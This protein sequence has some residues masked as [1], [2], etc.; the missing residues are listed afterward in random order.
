VRGGFAAIALTACTAA[1]AGTAAGAFAQAYSTETPQPR[2][3]SAATLRAAATASELHARFERGL[4]AEAAAAWPAAIAEF[5]RIIALDPGEPR[6]STARYDLAIALAH[7][8]AYE[9]AA[10]LLSDALARDPGFAAAAA[11]LVSVEVLAGN[12]PRARAAAERFVRIAPDA[13]RAHYARGLLALHDGDLSTARSDFGALIGNDP[14]YAI[15]HYDLALVE[16]RAER[17]DV[18]QAELQRAL[19]LA[20]RYA[21]A[22]FALGT[23]QLRLGRRSDARLTFDRASSDASDATLRTL[24]TDLRDR[25]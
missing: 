25:L 6:G 18:A 1:L 19:E 23:V 12:L 14:A 5:E 2:S 13:A 7:T 3:T 9:R 4:A 22:R 20:P 11:N 10:T 17:Y 15:A 21:R 8:G 16:I 24:A